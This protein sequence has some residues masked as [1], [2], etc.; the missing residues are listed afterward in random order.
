[1]SRVDFYFDPGCPQAFLAA[2]A[3]DPFVTDAFVSWRPVVLEDLR[4]AA[5]TS[6][7]E[8]P[9]ARAEIVRADLRRWGAFWGRPVEVT[10]VDGREAARAIWG[11]PR[12]QRPELAR[13][14]MRG[15]HE[16]G[17]SLRDARWVRTEAQRHGAEFDPVQADAGLAQQARS[18]ASVG[19][20]AVPSFVVDAQVI[21]GQDRL[22]AL[23]RSLGRTEVDLTRWAAPAWVGSVRPSRVEL[24][25]DFSSPFS[26]VASMAIEQVMARHGV[27]LLRRPILLGGLF[28][29]IGTPEVP[30]FAMPQAERRWM[31]KDAESWAEAL[32]IPFRFPEHFPMRSILPLR[33]ALARPELTAPLYAAA[34]A[35]NRRIDTPESLAEVVSEQG[36]DVNDIARRG[37]RP[38]PQGLVA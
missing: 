11:C 9:P 5:G 36:L 24:L 29:D 1:V 6:R 18:A 38:R 17:R 37:Q 3:M 10:E 35:D 25:H 19:V 22:G 27:P 12:Q 20:F 23:A 8:V 28:R 14:L 16:E 2:M 4:S 31:R 15:W 26:Y 21:Y 13:A 33:A 30:L 32:G 34:W 7:R